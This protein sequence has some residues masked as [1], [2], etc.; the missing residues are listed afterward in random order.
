MNAEGNSNFKQWLQSPTGLALAA[1]LGI[2]AYF[3]ITEH[4][5]HLFGLLP[6]ALLLL[7]PLLHLFMHR[8]HETHSE[9]KRKNEDVEES[10]HS[11]GHCH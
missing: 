8:G 5:A 2:A 10:E 3:L 6:C 7:C 4:S 1:F 9:E 11:Q